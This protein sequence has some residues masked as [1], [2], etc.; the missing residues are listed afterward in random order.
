L[1]ITE[2]QLVLKIDVRQPWNDF[3]RGV[4][5]N[6]PTPTEKEMGAVRKKA[7]LLKFPP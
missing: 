3:S 6:A 5:L 4:Q 2:Y 1:I 7:E